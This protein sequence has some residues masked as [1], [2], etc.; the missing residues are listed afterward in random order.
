[1]SH[2]PSRRHSIASIAALVGIALASFATPAGAETQFNYPDFSSVAGIQ[3]NGSA[4]QDVNVLR[5]TPSE[6]SKIGTAFSTTTIDPQ[7]SFQTYFGI[8]MH[9]GTLPKPADGMAFVIQSSIKGATAM[10][11]SI[12]GSL[13]YNGITPSMVVEFDPYYNFE[14][15][16]P[17]YPHISINAG[18]TG[19]HVACAVEGSTAVPPCTST[20]PFPVYGGPLYGWVEYDAASQHLKVFISQSTTKPATA[21]LDQLVAMGPLGTSAYVGFTASTGGASAVQDVLTWRMGPPAATPTTTTATPHKKKPKQRCSKGK[22]GK[23]KGKGKASTSAKG[24]AKGKRCGKK[25]GHKKG[26]GK[27]KGK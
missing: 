7:Q 17:L 5:L 12:G 4:K 14:A 20:L 2:S 27:A 10:S 18:T 9:D 1:V 25:K 19:A 26:K 13:G 8:S 15:P 6:P 16:D 3:L 11:P 22:A 21:L 24:K 23:S